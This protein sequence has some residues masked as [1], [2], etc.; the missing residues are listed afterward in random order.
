MRPIR[1]SLGAI[2]PSFTLF[3]LPGVAVVL[4]GSAVGDGSLVAIGALVLLTNLGIVLNYTHFTSLAVEGGDLV[5][6]TMLGMHEER[7][8]LGALQRIDAKRYAG[9]HA[10]VSAPH[11]VARGRESTVKVN[12]KPFRLS[13]F[14]PLLA[15]LRGV[16]A[17]I[18]MDPF[19]LAVANGEPVSKDVEVTRAGPF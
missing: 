5:Y 18:E 6:R 12:T 16:N 1:P 17:R 13:D 3:P 8:P 14:A 7:V 4:M 9:A 2:W 11:F 10:G 15:T 19:W